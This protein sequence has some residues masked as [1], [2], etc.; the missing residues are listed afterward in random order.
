L[1]HLTK[2]LDYNITLHVV[3]L[4]YIEDDFLNVVEKL[5]AKKLHPLCGRH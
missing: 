4:E 5:V 2:G 1:V 3:E